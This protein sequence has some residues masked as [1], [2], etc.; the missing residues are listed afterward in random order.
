VHVPIRI[1]ND[2]KAAKEQRGE[3]T[4][5]LIGPKQWV[6]DRCGDFIDAGVDEFCFMSIR[7]RP[8]VYQELTEEVLSA[9]N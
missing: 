9:F 5:S 6:I 1:V 7:Q 8:E 3:K 2:E 4:W